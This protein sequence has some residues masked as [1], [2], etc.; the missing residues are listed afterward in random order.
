MAG[1]GKPAYHCLELGGPCGRQ[2]WSSLRF[3]SDLRSSSSETRVPPPDPDYNVQVPA[4]ATIEF[5]GQGATVKTGN[6]ILKNGGEGD[7]IVWHPGSLAQDDIVQVDLDADHPLAVVS[8]TRVEDQATAIVRL[9]ND[10]ASDDVPVGVT[11][12]LVQRSS[13]PKV[14]DDPTGLTPTGQS[15]RATDPSNGRA[16]CYIAAFRFDYIVSG[17]GLST[18][19]FIDADGSFVFRS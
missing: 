2:Q 18:R 19:L 11:A 9:R 10:D 17:T 6:A 7:V 12:R 3:S 1:V 15:S 4:D 16:Q 8:V 5:Y 13:R 14:F